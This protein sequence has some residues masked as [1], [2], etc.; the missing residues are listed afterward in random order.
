M[1]N[2]IV[3]NWKCNPTTQKE[4]QSLFGRI[5]KGIKSTKAEVVICPPFVYLSQ[6]KGLSLGA[7]NIYFE[8]KGA[9]TGEI[10]APQLRDL[11]VNYV[12]LGHSERRKYFS[13]TDNQIN[14]KIKKTLGAKLKVILCIGENKHE[15]R[16][17]KKSE[18]LEK[19]ITEG[20]QG[21]SSS[22]FQVSSLVIAYE[23]IWAIGTGDNCS[24][25]ETM[26][27]V[28]F[29]R[30]VISKLYNRKIADNMRILYG[31]SVKNNN[32]LSYIKS[33]GANGLLVGSASLNAIEFIKIVSSI[34][35]K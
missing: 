34:K 10:S 2:L 33:S 14:K 5:K 23:P 35:N 9:F 30:K 25:D 21:V 11:K 31:G 26:S 13:E 22:K 1:K 12:I 27:S 8:D 6:L 24:V 15:W 7:Q 20:L 3:A 28:L 18:V 32:A 29:I 17:G 19:Q 4:A 16:D